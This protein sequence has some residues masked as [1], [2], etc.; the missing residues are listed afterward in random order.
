[1][2][3]ELKNIFRVFDEQNNELQRKLQQDLTAVIELLKTESKD[4]PCTDLKTEK[5]TVEAHELKT[6]DIGLIVHASRHHW[7][8]AMKQIMQEVARKYKKRMVL[9][10]V[11]DIDLD[12]SKIDNAVLLDGSKEE[13]VNSQI[14]PLIFNFVLHSKTSSVSKMRK[15]RMAKHIKVINPINKFYQNVLFDM[16][17]GITQTNDFLLPYIMLTATSL[18][19]FSKKHDRFYVLPQRAKKKCRAIVIKKVN[20]NEDSEQY[21]I[22]LGNFRQVVVG[23]KLY[24]SLKK[25]VRDKKCMLVKDPL[26][27]NWNYSPLEIRGYVQK[28][29]NGQWELL[30]LIAKKEIFAKDSIYDGSTGELAEILLEI[31]PDQLSNLKKK[32]HDAAIDASLILDFYIPNIGS[33]YFDFIVDLDANPYLLRV[34]GAEQEN[35][36][37]EHSLTWHKYILNIGLYLIFLSNKD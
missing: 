8:I 24:K 37:Y 18:K 21:E 32:I 7:F 27:V 17:S 15:L 28:N 2:N 11:N 13:V 26:P 12:K 31:F 22:K 36:L 9:F 5:P 25:L 6:V 4:E 29:I 30:D 33:C 23:E 14:P 34:G 10:T 3:E 19:T 20:S 16:I 1:M 35:F